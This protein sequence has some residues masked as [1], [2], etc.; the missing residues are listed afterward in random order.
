[1][2]GQSQA[3]GED[4]EAGGIES[5]TEAAQAGAF[6]VNRRLVHPVRPERRDHVWSYDMAL[7]RTTDGRALRI[8][9]II[10][11]YTRECLSMYVARSI[12]H[13]EVLEQLYELFLN[14]GVPEYIRSDNVLNLES[15]FFFGY[16]DPCS[17]NSLN[18]TKSQVA[19]TVI[20]RLFLP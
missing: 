1:M 16:T 2:G 5:A 9:V 14:R 3:C 6:M 17:I 19:S 12:R 8:L 4:L 10:D 13:Q 15:S 7:I 20:G 18:Q 11:E